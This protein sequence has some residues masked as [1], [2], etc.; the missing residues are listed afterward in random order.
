[1]VK[2]P[3]MFSTKSQRSREQNGGGLCL[4]P[5]IGVCKGAFLG[6]WLHCYIQFFYGHVFSI[7]GTVSSLRRKHT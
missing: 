3:S 7:G 6:N 2:V 1:M 5:V 4:D